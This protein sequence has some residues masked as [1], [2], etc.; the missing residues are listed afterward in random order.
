[1]EATGLILLWESDLYI[2][3]AR[4]KICSK[5]RAF[6]GSKWMTKLL[7]VDGSGHSIAIRC[8]TSTI[9]GASSVDAAVGQISPRRSESVGERKVGV[10]VQV[11]SRA[12][13]VEVKGMASVTGIPSDGLSHRD[14]DR[15]TQGA[16]ARSEGGIMKSAVNT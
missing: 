7:N 14:V 12:C 5:G 3:K 8:W 4:Q 10:V 2:E 16:P 13:V 1:M 15:G 9:V 11:A 6:A